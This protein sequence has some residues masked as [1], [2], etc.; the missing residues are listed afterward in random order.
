[1]KV[2]P[3]LLGAAKRVLRVYVADGAGNAIPAMHV[4]KIPKFLRSTAQC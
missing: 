4:F 1:M 3:V 2:V